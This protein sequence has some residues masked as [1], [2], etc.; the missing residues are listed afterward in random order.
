MNA[1]QYFPKDFVKKMG[2]VKSKHVKV[3]R[4]QKVIKERVSAKR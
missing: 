1:A 4:C 3:A 2:E